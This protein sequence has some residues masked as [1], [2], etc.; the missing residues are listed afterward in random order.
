MLSGG[1]RCEVAMPLLDHFHPPLSERQHVF[2]DSWAT[3]LSLALNE[4]LPEGYVAEPNVGFGIEMDETLFEDS[5]ATAAPAA[6]TPLP[7]AQSLPFEPTEAVVE[8]R[9]ISRRDGPVLAGA[10]ELVSGENKYRPV[11]RDALVTKCAAYLQAGVGLVLVDVVTIHTADL[12]ADL[13]ARLG[14]DPIA[15]PGLFAAAY[16]AVGLDGGGR[17]DTWRESVALGRPLPT[18]PLWLRGSLCLPVDLEAAYMRT[19][20]EQKVQPAA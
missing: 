16:R 2:L 6:W 8:V 15:E 14:S 7:P 19:C 3:N 4:L 18:L 17:L 13:L 1:N 11:Y 5:D 20:V 9:V 10:V 12:H